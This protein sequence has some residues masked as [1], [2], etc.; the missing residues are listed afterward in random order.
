VPSGGLLQENCGDTLSPT[1]FGLFGW[2]A[3]LLATFLGIS[4]PSSKVVDV[5]LKMSAALAPVAATAKLSAANAG[6]NRPR[7][8]RIVVFLVLSSPF[9][10]S[11]NEQSRNEQSRNQQSRREQ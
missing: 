11:R 5:R 9:E 1:Q 8:A 10:Q 2:L 3:L 7:F 4:L 6:V